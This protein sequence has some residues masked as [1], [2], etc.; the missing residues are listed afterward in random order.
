[1]T[2][3]FVA[4]LT[5]RITALLDKADR[6][7][8]PFEAEAYVLK[9]QALA[10]MASIDLAAA[11]VR[12]PEQQ[13]PVTRTVIIGEKGRRAN[14]HLIGLFVVVAHANSA[15]VDVASDSTYVIGY[16]MPR[17]LDVVEAL[18]AAI[19]VQMVAAAGTYITGGAW[20]GETY[21]QRGTRRTRKPFTAQTARAAFYRAYVERIGERLQEAR[22]EGIVESDRATAGGAGELVLRDA[23]RQVRDYHRRTSSA[24][25]RW[26]G[27]SGGARPSGTAGEQGRAAAGRA[28]LAGQGELGQRG[29]LGPGHPG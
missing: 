21:V 8:N 9:A 25:G 20:R 6:T 3:R 24:R 7:D 13:E 29:R 19:S 14:Q 4:D 26:G 23:E 18:F 10:T 2:E 22:R 16:G 27:Y 15:H 12:A 11:R 1:M 5:R 17:D 28:R